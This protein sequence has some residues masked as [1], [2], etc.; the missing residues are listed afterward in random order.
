MPDEKLSSSMKRRM[1]GPSLRS[2]PMDP[3]PLIHP[4]KTD[5]KF[6]MDNDAGSTDEETG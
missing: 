1:D 6:P 3:S 4:I 5:K 2:E